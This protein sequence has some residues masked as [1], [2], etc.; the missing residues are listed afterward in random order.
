MIEAP[1]PP[2]WYVVQTNA[3]EER[4]ARASI[5]QASLEVYLPMIAKENKTRG[6]YPSP[7][8][9]SYLFARISIGAPGCSALFSARGVRCVLGNGGKPSAIPDRAI[10][11]IRLREEAGLIKIGLA[12]P[13]ERF[14]AGDRVLIKAG[15]WSSL[16]AVFLEPIDANRCRV[17]I[18]I[19][20]DSRTATT[21]FNTLAS[22]S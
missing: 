1:S 4:L 8:F 5:A 11:A 22:E 7:L 2:R 13:R 3:H 18:Q 15:Q 20:G 14:K 17:L 16:E 12:E 6:V 10:E 19:L 21:S 9:P